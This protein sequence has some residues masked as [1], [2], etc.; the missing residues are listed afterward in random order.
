MALEL[1]EILDERKRGRASCG[2]NTPSDGCCDSLHQDQQSPSEL[3]TSQEP[4]PVNW[5][6]T[7]DLM[8]P[9]SVWHLWAD[10]SAAVSCTDIKVQLQ[11]LLASSLLLAQPYIDPMQD[12]VFS[13]VK[14]WSSRVSP[15]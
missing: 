5:T 4:A 15:V 9:E 8:I 2:W 11:G 14:C 12:T 10:P 1:L 13:Y 7:N 3:E 6:D